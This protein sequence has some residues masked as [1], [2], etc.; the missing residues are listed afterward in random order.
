MYQVIN[1]I[2]KK[3]A[4]IEYLVK[5]IK[6]NQ[7]VTIPGGRSSEIIL[8]ILNNKIKEN[9]T[10]FLTDERIGVSSS[11]RNE[12]ILVKYIN[13]KRNHNYIKF[14]LF[15][16]NKI[17]NKNLLSF[18]GFGNDGHFASIFPEV[19]NLN[20]KKKNLQYIFNKNNP[21]PYRITL[22]LNFFKKSNEI[23][24]LKKSLNGII[25]DKLNILNSKYFHLLE[26][27]YKKKIKIIFY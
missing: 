24:F 21:F 10:I 8:K 16:D 2:N 3:N 25:K 20:L 13:L 12:K 23:I 4:C 1:F 9:K 22:T 14:S 15:L 7:I 6:K 5:K 11:D 27:M 19:K 18:V 26:S 17:I